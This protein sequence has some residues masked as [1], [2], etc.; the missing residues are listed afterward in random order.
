MNA[1]LSVAAQH[2]VILQ[3]DDKTYPIAAAS[4]LSRALC[5][6]QNELSNT[7]TV[8]HL[9]AFIATSVLLQYGVW[10]STDFCSTQDNGVVSFDPEKDRIFA[11][12]SALKQVFLQSVSLVSGKLSVLL[13]HVAYNPRDVLVEAAQISNDTLARYQA[14]F[15]YNRPLNIEH[16]NMPRLFAGNTDLAISTPWK[17]FHKIPEASDSIGMRYAHIISELCL[18]LSFLPESKPPESVSTEKPL[19]PELVRYI[20]SFP[21]MCRGLFVSM[22]Q[23]SDPH[24]LFLLYHFYRAVRILCPLDQCWWAYKRAMLSETFLREWLVRESGRVPS[25]P[26]RPV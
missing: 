26:T 12:S 21:M 16:L 18:I 22:L 20:F 9:D 13:T 17:N 2:L 1:M 19:L 11:L 6:F 15:S 14:F 23:Q 25:E 5:L 3:P 8:I 7:S 10:A 4:H 24:A